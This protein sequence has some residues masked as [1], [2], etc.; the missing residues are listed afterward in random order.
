MRRLCFA[1]DLEDNPALIA[2]YD[3]YHSA[4][5]V[6][7]EVIEDI[8]AEGYQDMQIWRTGNRLFMVAEVADDFPRD[9]RS[10]ATREICDRWESLMDKYQRRLPFAP[11]HV[12][13]MPMHCIF[14]LDQ[15]SGS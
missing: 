10:D 12:K 3:G 1:L 14:D 11:E 4:G 8:H 13:W 6:W 7:A 15:H 2:A 5:A 9:S